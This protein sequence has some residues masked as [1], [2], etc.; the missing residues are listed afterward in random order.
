MSISAA[1]VVVVVVVAAR[2]P[3]WKF[4]SDSLHEDEELDE[5]DDDAED[6][7]AG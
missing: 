6:G 7:E 3:T 1:V 2:R 4:F 5:V